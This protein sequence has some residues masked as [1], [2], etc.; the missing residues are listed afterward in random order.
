MSSFW[1]LLFVVA[2]VDPRLVALIRGAI[3]RINAR[4]D[5]IN[6]F[7]CLTFSGAV[8]P[9]DTVNTLQFVV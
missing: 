5:K 6:S 2:I 3:I 4:R 7:C 8:N 9:L 1:Y